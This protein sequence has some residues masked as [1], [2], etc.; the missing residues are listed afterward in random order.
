MIV[1]L[2]LA[3]AKYVMT[4]LSTNIGRA[5]CPREQSVMKSIASFFVNMVVSWGKAHR[6]PVID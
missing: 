2:F 3:Y 1:A 4:A 6:L 5:E